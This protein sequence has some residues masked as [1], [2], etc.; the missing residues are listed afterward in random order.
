MTTVYFDI[1]PRVVEPTAQVRLHDTIVPLK[2]PGPW[3][4]EVEQ[5]DL[6]I[7]E[8]S[9]GDYGPLLEELADREDLLERL[10][11]DIALNPYVAEA[12]A[13]R[14][15]M[16]LAPPATIELLSDGKLVGAVPFLVV[17]SAAQHLNLGLIRFGGEAHPWAYGWSRPSPTGQCI[18]TPL[19]RACL[20]QVNPADM[21]SVHLAVKAQNDALLLRARGRRLELW[22]LAF[23]SSQVTEILQHLKRQLSPLQQIRYRFFAAAH[24]RMNKAKP[25]TETV[26]SDLHNQWA[27]DGVG[28]GQWGLEKIED[29][30]LNGVQPIQPLEDGRGRWR[31]VYDL[32]GFDQDRSRYKIPKVE[33]YMSEGTATQ[34][35][36]VD[37]IRWTF[38][39]SRWRSATPSNQ[40]RGA[41]S[42][43]SHALR[44]VRMMNFLAGQYEWHVGRGHLLA[45]ATQTALTRLPKS[46]EVYKFLW[47]FVR[48]VA[49]IDNFGN[50]IIVGP[51]GILARGTGLTAKGSVDYAMS[52]MGQLDWLNFSVRSP[53]GP[54][55]RYARVAG[56]VWKRINEYVELHAPEISTN[57]TNRLDYVRLL[58]E[59]TRQSVPAAAHIPATKYAAPVRRE[60]AAL[61]DAPSRAKENGKTCAFHQVRWASGKEESDVRA[62]VA[63]II[64]NATFVHSWVNDQLLLR[65]GDLAVAPLGMRSTDIPKDALSYWT[66]CAPEPSE[67]ALQLLISEQLVRLR[68]GHIRP[69]LFETHFTPRSVREFFALH[70]DEL[71][72]N[73]YSYSRVRLSP[74]V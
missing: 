67:G 18:S 70:E 4:F 28:P 68:F 33:V 27:R 59:V 57:P 52:A 3:T 20:V 23:T 43:W 2:G 64:F 32:S 42:K 35:P 30:L 5:L 50:D 11:G 10:P 36:V 34:D 40:R 37:K 60:I 25:T 69:T 8:R 55:D 7:P 15:P 54:S 53:L 13:G 39:G 45:E 12:L 47:P 71:V 44:I 58:D 72:R 48:G 9:I 1:E 56:V 74:N 46:S 19:P 73:G 61:A 38:D 41:W 21:G 26:Q 24:K 6:R 66:N 29:V 49:E 14:D 17:R 62:F 31:V 22:T 63:Y 51:R 16:D 65:G